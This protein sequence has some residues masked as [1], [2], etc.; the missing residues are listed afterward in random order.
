MGTLYN[1]E[2]H[3]V[4]KPGGQEEGTPSNRAIWGGHTTLWWKTPALPVSIDQVSMHTIYIKI[5]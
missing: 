1:N 4:R 5:V 2:D 3:Q